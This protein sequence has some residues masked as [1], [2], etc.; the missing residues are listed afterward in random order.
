M[1][2]KNLL[3]IQARMGSKRLPGKVMLKIG[4]YRIIELLFKR[5]SKAK[6]VDQII[7]DICAQIN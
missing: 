2:L 4:K 3:V 1:F 5:L 6:M 7:A